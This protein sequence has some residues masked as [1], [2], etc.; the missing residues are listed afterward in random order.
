MPKINPT[1]EEKLT[2]IKICQHII[3]SKEDD[4]NRI[5]IR[6]KNDKYI[7]DKRLNK[8]KKEGNKLFQEKEKYI[9]IKKKII[10]T[11]SKNKNFSNYI[12]TLKID[13]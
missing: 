4:I 1:I 8:L 6:I 13:D 11:L 10:E 12:N 9:K 3:D 7:E 5:L 2:Y